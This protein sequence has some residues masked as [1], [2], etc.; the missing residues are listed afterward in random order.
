MCECIGLNQCLF[1]TD[2]GIR[3]PV[4]FM[5]VDSARIELHNGVV[6]TIVVRAR[7]AAPQMHNAAIY[8]MLVNEI[9]HVLH[10]FMGL[11]IL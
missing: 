9:R 1:G 11:V 5:V 2:D 8:A 4:F 6:A 3:Q 7:S 10:K